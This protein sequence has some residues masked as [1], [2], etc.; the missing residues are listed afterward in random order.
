MLD[1]IIKMLENNETVDEWLVSD[2]EIESAELFFVGKNLDMNRSKKVNHTSITVYKNFLEDGIKYKGS[3]STRVSPVMSKSEIEEKI[4][5]AALAAALVKN[6]H[7]ELAQPSDEP[8]AQIQSKFDL[9]TL[10]SYLPKLVSSLYKN[11]DFEHGKINSCEFFLEKIQTRIVNSLGV[12]ESY[13]SHEGQIE[14]VVDW[15]ESDEEVEI[16]EII[17]FS[18]F[19]P[20]YI[21]NVA[22]QTLENAR[23][24]AIALPMPKISDVPIILVK[25][26]VNEFLR[27]Y[28]EKADAM[29]VYQ[30]YSS[31]KVGD[32]MQGDNVKGDKINV[33][34]LPEIENS[35]ASRYIDADGVKLHET[36]LYKEGK[37]MSYHGSKR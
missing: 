27:Y 2:K 29:L 22:L 35:V 30:K 26:N 33:S 6:P 20:A 8:L 23:L 10:S 11:N 15:K 5:Q 31:A 28:V 19:D 17:D 32:N 12:D 18:D 1:Q 36:A 37:L 13:T 21:E 16:I 14:L 9:D 34:L 7:Y 3:A 25:E 24:R 4:E